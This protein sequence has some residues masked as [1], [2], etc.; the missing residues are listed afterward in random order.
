MLAERKIDG[1]KETLLL[2]ATSLG[3]EE[4]SE[5][6]ERRFRAD[7]PHVGVS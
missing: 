1:T 2:V 3:R 7:Y 6:E 5:F 4:A